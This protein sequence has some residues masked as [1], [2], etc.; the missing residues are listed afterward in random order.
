MS[1]VDRKCK[2]CKVFGEGE[3]GRGC[4]LLPKCL[5]GMGVGMR[6]FA[7]DGVALIYFI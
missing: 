1:D 6:L 2:K 3:E 7:K 5:T 4:D